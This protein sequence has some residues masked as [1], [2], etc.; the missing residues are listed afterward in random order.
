[1][2]QLAVR[3]MNINEMS[4]CMVVEFEHFETERESS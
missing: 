1:M 3:Q 2:L 4:V